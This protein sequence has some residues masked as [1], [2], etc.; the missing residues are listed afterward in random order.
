MNKYNRYYYLL[1]LTH[2]V[3]HAIKE[4]PRR[5]ILDTAIAATAHTPLDKGYIV[6]G[7]NADDGEQLHGVFGHGGRTSLQRPR[8]VETSVLGTQLQRHRPVLLPLRM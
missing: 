6:A 3:R 2:P 4:Q 8:V 7:S 1:L 5:I